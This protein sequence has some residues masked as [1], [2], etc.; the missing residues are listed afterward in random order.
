MPLGEKRSYHYH[1]HAREDDGFHEPEDLAEDATSSTCGVRGRVHGG[2]SSAGCNSLCSRVRWERDE[3]GL[4]ELVVELETAVGLRPTRRFC[5]DELCT[6]TFT[7]LHSRSVMVVGWYEQEVE[8]F[9]AE[10]F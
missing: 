6:D 10:V 9:L 3:V 1:S 7:S 5:T 2:S 8:S 4:L